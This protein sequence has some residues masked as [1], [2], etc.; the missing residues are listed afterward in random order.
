MDVLS[1]WISTICL[2]FLIKVYLWIAG[3]DGERE[4][5]IKAFAIHAKKMRELEVRLMRLEAA[6]R[7][8][9]GR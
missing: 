1:F 2:G 9:N 5:T 7:S 8:S 4:A 3:H 6:R